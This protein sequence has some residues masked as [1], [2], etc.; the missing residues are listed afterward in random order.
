MLAALLAACP[1]PMGPDWQKVVFVP[2]VDIPFG[3]DATV[4]NYNLQA[5]VP[6]PTAGTVPVKTNTG[7]GD[8]DIAVVWKD[9]AGQALGES[10]DQF[11][12]GVVYQAD[13]TLTAKNGYGFD[14]GMRFRYQPEDTVAVQPADNSSAN[15]RSLSAVRYFPTGEGMTIPSP[16]DLTALVPAPVMSATPVT[17]FFAGTYGGTV[18]WKSGGSGSDGLFKAITAYGAE[19]TLYPAVGY[20]FP[21][22]IEVIHSGAT[23]ATLSFT[24]TAG[25]VSGAVAFPATGTVPALAVTDADLTYKVPSPVRGGTPVE[26]FSAPQY[27]GR[28]DWF[29][30]G[31]TVPHSVF[32]ANMTYTAK[33]TLT[34]TSGYTFGRLAVNFTHADAVAATVDNGNGTITVTTTFPA[35]TAAAA[36]P[37]NDWDL[38]YRIPAPVRGGTP[39]TYFAAPQYTGNVT[40]TSGGQNL[41]G[42]FEANTAY[43]AAITLTAA[44]GYTFTGV[45]AS[46]THGGAEIITHLNGNTVRVRFHATT[47]AT[48]AQVSDLNLTGKVPAPVRGGTP[49]SYFSAPEYTGTVNWSVTSGGQALGGLFEAGTAYTATVT[50]TAVSGFTFAGVGANAFTHSGGTAANAAGSSVVT[51]AFPA[52]SGVAAIMISDR[53]LTYKIP[54]PVRG[55]TPVTY[56]S[57]PQYTGTVD[58]FVGGSSAPH[59][60]F[61]ANMTYTARVTLSAAAGYTFG[62]PAAAFSHTGASSIT[63]AA[64]TGVTV[65]II[66]PATTSAAAVTV[67]DVD[68]TARVP[69]PVRDGTAAVYFAAPQYTGSVAWKQTGSNTPLEGLFGA[70]TAYTA[71]VTLTAAS[72]YTFTGVGANAFTCGGAASVSNSADSGTVVIAFPATNTTPATVVNDLNLTG[73]VAAPVRG[74]TPAGYFSTS[75][76]TGTVAWTVTSGGQAL[77][78]LFEAGT[79][80][81]ATVTLTAVSGFTFA[82]VGANAFTHSGGTAANAANT[83]L[84]TIS[85]PATTSVAAIPVSDLDL[86]YK[87]P[88]PVKDG[89]PA[90]YISDPQYTGTVTWAVY[91]GG[92]ALS[93]VFGAGTAYTATVTLAAAS[94]YT[95]TGVGANAF[96][97]AHRSSITNAANTGVITIVFP[98]TTSVAATVVGDLDLTGKVPAPVSGGTPVSYFSAPEY[99]GTVAWAVTSGSSLYGLFAA[100][101]YYTATVTLTAA[102]GFTLTGIDGHFTHARAAGITAA[103]DNTGTVTVTIAFPTTDG[104]PAAAVNDLN[105]TAKVHAPVWGGTPVSY[106]SAPQYAGTVTWKETVTGTALSGLFGA[107]TAYTATVTLTAASGYTFTGVAANSFTHSGKSTIGNAGNSGVVTITFPATTGAAAAIV[108]DLNLT[109][110]V[111]APVSGGTPV[112]YFSAPQYTG[113][114]AWKR[115]DNNAALSGLFGAGTYY[116][117]TVTLTAASGYTFTGVTANSFTHSDNSTISNTMNSGVVTITFPATGGTAVTVTE[118]DLTARIA[119]PV[120]AGI[121]TTYFSAS[122]Y[123]GTVAWKRTDNGTALSGLF[124]ANTAYTATVT[125]TAASGYTFTGVTANSFTH[126][127]RSTI[128]NAENSGVVTITF[129]ATSPASATAIN[130]VNLT[131]SV[132]APVTSSNP[133]TSFNAGTYSGNIAWTTV[134][135]VPVTQFEADTVYRA[136]VSLYPAAGYSFPST[137]PVTLGSINANFTG[138]PRQGTITFPETGGLLFYSGPFS[139][140]AADNNDSVIDVIRAA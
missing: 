31:T 66:F 39:V 90:V 51:L 59:S 11:V 105:L 36:V 83:G 23:I 45:N 87:V 48:A 67:S 77:G 128:G 33:V 63:T 135:G 52:T 64:G 112:S 46:F 44:S 81:T 126:S 78:G 100:S 29:V 118:V 95:F 120:S 86:T 49:V 119:V 41:G 85:F 3:A 43:T 111:H 53:D 62:S 32:Q 104:T 98:A 12:L 26:Y 127:G 9:A 8:V 131:T 106:F 93:G 54:A 37:V 92:Q 121:P 21:A 91:P 94:G 70:N 47:S 27:T 40:W 5:Y 84:V 114:V 96:T 108:G 6:V 28:V 56:F 115:T 134:G 22:N 124:G 30:G 69:K 58:W 79:A 25:T 72:G 17:S 103:A 1:L 14:P 138:E 113:N 139:G 99:M 65:T 42:L 71:T 50:L 35:T 125:L 61:Q 122:Q 107:N 34:P 20:M 133:V 80:Y 18:A 68:L 15:I 89:T 38:T 2:R 76:Y 130:S 117:A 88:A 75:Q 24:R 7:R 4:G 137:L 13:I 73:K 132:P 82:G 102:S 57:T 60:V 10:F 123:T 129:P 116:T 101:T 136:T 110:K 74:G 19:V 55:G 109:A 16:I 97:H 140:S